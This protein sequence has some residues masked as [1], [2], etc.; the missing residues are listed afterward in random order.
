MRPR[1]LL[2]LNE[3]VQTK[4][5]AALITRYSPLK[6]PKIVS[7]VAKRYVPTTAVL[8]WGRIQ[9]AEGGDRICCREMIKTGSLGCDCTYIRVCLPIGITHSALM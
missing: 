7:F 6:G 3:N 5:A 9:V 8:Q 1:K 4:L 2:T